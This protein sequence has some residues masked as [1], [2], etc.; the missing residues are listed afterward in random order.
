MVMTVNQYR[1]AFDISPVPVP[2]PDAVGPG[3]FDGIY[4]M[5]SFVTI[6]TPDLARSVAYWTEALDF[7]ELFAA[8]DR[9]VHLRRWAFQDVLL[10]PTANP[11]PDPTGWTN[12]ITVSFACV[13]SE[14]DPLL[15][16]WRSHPDSEAVESPGCACDPPPKLPPNSALNSGQTARLCSRRIGV[17]SLPGVRRQ[18]TSRCRRRQRRSDSS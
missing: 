2:S 9:L 15:N 1:A 14:V 6:P 4:G 12:A 7:F 16:Q 5:P 18:V 11:A 3:H 10:I 17:G 8:P 13:L